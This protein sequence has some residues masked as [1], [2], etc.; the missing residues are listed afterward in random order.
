MKSNEYI[1]G[2]QYKKNP[3]HFKFIVSQEKQMITNTMLKVLSES[4]TKVG[5]PSGTFTMIFLSSATCILIE[6]RR[7]FWIL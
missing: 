4:V 7:D 3:D 1:D 5:V 6:R 2:C